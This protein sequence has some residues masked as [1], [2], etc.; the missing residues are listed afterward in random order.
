MLRKASIGKK[1][2]VVMEFGKNVE[3]KG[4]QKDR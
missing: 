4:G 3:G 2:K 1:V